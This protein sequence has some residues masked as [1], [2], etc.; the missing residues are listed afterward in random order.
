[1]SPAAQSWMSSFVDLKSDKSVF[2]AIT[3]EVGEQDM[4]VNNNEAKSLYNSL[5]SKGL[6]VEYISRPGTH[7]WVFWMA[8]LPKA[9]AAAGKSF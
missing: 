5:K 8:C 3:I 6:T 7:D 1:M 4:T 2:P 9:L